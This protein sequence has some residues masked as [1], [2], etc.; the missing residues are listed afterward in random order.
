MLDIAHSVFNAVT[1]VPINE[2]RTEI[3]AF[4]SVQQW[5]EIIESAGLL[6]TMISEV[7]SDDPTIDEMLC[8]Y[9]PPFVHYKPRDDLPKSSQIP[10]MAAPVLPAI[11]NLLKSV[12]SAVLAMMRSV[13]EGFIEKLPGLAQGIVEMAKNFSSGGVTTVVQQVIEKSTADLKCWLERFKPY[14]DSTDTLGG[15]IPVDLVP[16]ELFL[17]VPALN[18]KVSAF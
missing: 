7:Q 8:F 1:G 12:P 17:I 14:F 13:I 16:P 3:R 15:D 2:E 10:E 18:R 11:S 6:D 9:K 4:R 5:R